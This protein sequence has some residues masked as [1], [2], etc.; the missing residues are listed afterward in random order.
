MRYQQPC[1]WEQ[2]ATYSKLVQSHIN[3]LDDAKKPDVWENSQAPT[4]RCHREAQQTARRLAIAALGLMK[5]KKAARPFLNSFT[6]S[7]RSG[8]FRRINAS[9]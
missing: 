7:F 8:S 9:Q 4:A 1:K 5:P 6:I 2:P 3:P